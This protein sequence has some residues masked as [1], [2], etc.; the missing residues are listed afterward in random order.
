MKLNLE[1]F[2]KYQLPAILWAAFIYIASSVPSGRLQWWLFHRFDKLVHIAVFYVL[3]LLVYRALHPAIPRTA[4][5]PRR[6]VFMFV[7]VIGYGL[8]DELHQT[9]TGRNFDS[10]DF[11]A[12]AGGGVLAGLTIYAFHFF[13]RRRQPPS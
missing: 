7:I 8:F 1:T 2:V 5:S 10:K 13:R 4:L 6:I 3:G 9:F 12:D 11:L